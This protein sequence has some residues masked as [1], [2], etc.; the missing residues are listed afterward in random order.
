MDT[1]MNLSE[2]EDIL[3]EKLRQYYR[4]EFAE[5][6]PV[7]VPHLFQ[8]K[9]D[10]EIAA[11]LTA[12]ISWGS[13]KSIIRTATY[14]MECMD[15]EPHNF[16]LHHTSGDIKKM[17]KFYYRTF[18]HRDM[19]YFI[20]ALRNVYQNHS[21]LEE[22]F[23]PMENKKA[24]DR[25]LQGLK[26][27]R[28][29]FLSFRPLSRTKKHIGN[30]EEGS[31]CKRLCMFLRWMVRECRHGIDFGIWKRITPSDLKVPLDVHTSRAFHYL[32]W[33]QKQ[34]P[35]WKEVVRLTQIL[36]KLNPDDPVIYDFALFGL[37]MEMKK[38]RN[39]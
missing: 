22:I 31:A 6:D 33:M 15:M 37:G 23:F 8:K 12:T 26:N 5:E 38:E 16:I 2:A 19:L 7:C 35:S 20:R 29:V 1:G 10:I 18:Q 14:W 30:P 3:N 17:E 34:N 24:G 9:Q 28:K 27:F 25:V 36:K 39:F 21:S 32:G 11:F 4:P 13:R